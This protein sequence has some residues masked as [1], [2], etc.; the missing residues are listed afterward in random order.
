MF[1]WTA[2]LSCAR[3][4]LITKEITLLA[5]WISCAMLA[6]LSPAGTLS[7]SVLCAF[8]LQ[9][10]YLGLFILSVSMLTPVKQVPV[11]HLSI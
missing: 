4:R 1:T 10:K 7:I 6:L 2:T 9:V 5:I 8:T 3:H 11:C